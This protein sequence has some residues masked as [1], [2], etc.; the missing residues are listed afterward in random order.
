MNYLR[1]RDRSQIEFLPACIEDYIEPNSPA[2]FI[3]AF[4]AGL[5][6]QKLGFTRAQPASTGR[7]GYHPAD[8]LKLYL[9]GYLNRI[10]SSRRL[11]AEAARNLE[12]MWLMRGLRPDF[13]TIADFRKDNRQ[14]F[15]PLFKQFNLL[16]RK[17]ELFGAELVAIDGCKFKALNNP[18][19][20]YSRKQLDEL[21]QKIEQRIEDYLK[22][23]DTQD[24][25][26]QGVAGAPTAQALEQKIAQ[27]KEQQGNYQQLLK[28]L[29]ENGQNEVSLVDQDS[30]AMQKVGVGY[31]VQVAVDAK[32][33]LIVEPEVVQSA[34]DR[35][36]LSKMALAAKTELG[37][38]K[39]Q[40]TADAG[41]HEADQ[42]E[43]CEK[44]SIE[45]YVPDTGKT[46]GRSTGGKPVFPKEQFIYDR[47]SDSYRCP[48]GQTLNRGVVSKCKG[49]E[50]AIYYNV[51]AC[52]QCSLKT[53]C[54]LG[55]Y[56]AIARRLNETVVERA[57][58][59]LEKYPQILARRKEIVEHVFGTLR[60][61][62]HDHFLTKGLPKVKAEFSLSALTYNLRRVLN[63]FSVEQLIEELT[64]NQ[65][66]AAS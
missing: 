56:R 13:K 3:D 61:W 7:P 24:G 57:A 1:G 44:A 27:L 20:H 37:A 45:T 38:Q 33:H 25:E 36:Q 49:K 17:M 66:V 21:L 23:L 52:S 2:R 41:Y 48:A 59:R 12:L 22:E 16:C 5:D 47:A 58:Q 54:T 9:Y 51:A 14:A 62:G 43:S 55:R 60:N 11:E 53:Q 8:L 26:L 30:R 35:G 18:R 46:S 10:R 15:K 32:H 50:R 31:N 34:C 6:F 64:K 40:V 42:L 28:G 65:A 39:L 4:V 19:Y 29:Q 63:L